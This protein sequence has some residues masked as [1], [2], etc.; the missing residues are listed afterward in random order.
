MH[1]AY[2]AL[3]VSSNSRPQTIKRDRPADN[4]KLLRYR[5]Y[6]AACHKYSREIAEIQQYMPGWLPCSPTV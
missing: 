3:N 5:A 1:L 2:S 4:E 6:L